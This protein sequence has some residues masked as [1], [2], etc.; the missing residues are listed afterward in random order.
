MLPAKLVLLLFS[1][2][3]SITVICREVRLMDP[4][5]GLK[6]NKVYLGFFVCV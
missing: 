1:F 2:V 4:L 6:D 5:S 3:S